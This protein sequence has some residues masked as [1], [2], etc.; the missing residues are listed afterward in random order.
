MMSVANVADTSKFLGKT[1]KLASTVKSKLS[2][3][4]SSKRVS[5]SA[6]NAE[7]DKRPS[8]LQ[9]SRKSEEI[10]E[11]D[12]EASKESQGGSKER[13]T[14]S[15]SA[16]NFPELSKLDSDSDSNLDD[17]R[18]TSSGSDSDTTT[19]RTETDELSEAGSS[20]VMTPRSGGSDGEGAMRKSLED[21]CE[22]ASCISTAGDTTDLP[23][24]SVEGG[25]HSTEEHSA[26]ELKKEAKRGGFRRSQTDNP[27]LSKGKKGGFRKS[28]TESDSASLSEH[29]KKERRTLIATTVEAVDEHGKIEIEDC[30]Q[31]S[32]S[33]L[34]LNFANSSSLD[35]KP[36]PPS[37]R[38]SQASTFSMSIPF[39]AEP[40]EVPSPINFSEEDT[41]RVAVRC[42]PF[43]SR[44]REMGCQCVV[45]MSGKTTTLCQMPHQDAPKDFTYDYS[46]WSHDENDSHFASQETVY[47]DVGKTILSNS[48]HGINGC[49]FAYGQTG[50]GKSHS[51]IG[52]PEAP[53]VVPRFVQEIFIHKASYD[54][55]RTGSTEDKEIRLWISYVEIYNEELRDLLAPGKDPVQMRI[56]DHP[57]M[58]VCVPGLTENACSSPESVEKLMDFGNKKRVVGA[59]Q[60]NAVSSR[61]HAVFRL[62]V[63]TLEGLP[64]DEEKEKA[65]EDTRKILSSQC[66]LVD[67]AG[68]ERQSKTQAKGQRLKEGRAINQ[69]LSLLGIVIKELSELGSKKSSAQIP[70]RSSKL[71]FLLKDSLAGNSRTY[72]IAA[73]SPADN[74]LVETLSTLR[75]AS[76]V[77]MIKTVARVNKDGKDAQIEDLMEEIARLKRKMLGGSFGNADDLGEIKDRQD[78]CGQMSLSYEEQLK[79][80]KQM[81]KSREEALQDMAL[82]H[83]E[84]AGAFGLD[85]KTPYL[86][87]MSDDPM[88]AGCLLFILPEGET[89]TIGADHSNKINLKGVGIPA[90]LCKIQNKDNTTILIK[91]YSD[92]GRVVVDGRVL[93]TGV[94]KTLNNGSKIFLGRAYALKLTMPLLEDDN[95]N[96]GNAPVK[97]TTHAHSSLSLEGLDDEWNALEDSVAWCSI[98]GQL[99]ETLS[100]LTEKRGRELLEEVKECCK[101]CDEATEISNDVRVEKLVFDIGITLDSLDHSH[102]VFVRIWPDKADGTGIQSLSEDQREWNCLF[103]NLEK[104][105]ER[106]HLMRDAYEEFSRIGCFDIDFLLD[107]WK[108]P[109]QSDVIRR[110][111]ALENEL[112][113]TTYQ[114]EMAKHQKTNV[115][116]K[117][118]MFWTQELM[119]PLRFVLLSW[120]SVAEASAKSKRRRMS[121]RQSMK[122]TNLKGSGKRMLRAF[123]VAPEKPLAAVPEIPVAKA[124]PSRTL[125]DAYEDVVISARMRNNLTKMRDQSDVSQVVAKIFTKTQLSSGPA[126]LVIMAKALQCEIEAL[127]QQ[128]RALQHI[129]EERN[130][131]NKSIDE[132]IDALETIAREKY[133]E[134]QKKQEEIER[135]IAKM[136]WA[137]AQLAQVRLEKE[138]EE[139]RDPAEDEHIGVA[140]CT[141]LL[142]A[143][144]VSGI[145]SSAPAL[146]K[147]R[148]IQ[149][150][151]QGWAKGASAAAEEQAPMRRGK[152]APM[153]LP[154]QIRDITND[155][156]RLTEALNS[157][158]ENGALPPKPPEITTPDEDLD[159]FDRERDPVWYDSVKGVVSEALKGASHEDRRSLKVTQI[160]GDRYM[161]DIE[162]QLVIGH[163]GEVHVQTGK[164]LFPLASFMKHWRTRVEKDNAAAHERM[165]ANETMRKKSS[166]QGSSIGLGRA[167]ALGSSTE[168]EVSNRQTTF[169]STSARSTVSALSIGDDKAGRPTSRMTSSPN[170]DFLYGAYGDLQRPTQNRV[171]PHQVENFRRDILRELGYDGSLW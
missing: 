55:K 166:P 64:P 41:I 33:S 101:L 36:P 108:E 168:K 39:S 157:L 111:S 159:F 145:R 154:G 120:K 83:S 114:K 171:M 66:N 125:L 115:F 163:G 18:G 14:F 107:P 12:C 10:A 136:D 57:K 59:T 116:S 86:L 72:M 53:G 95:G 112:Q 153:T 130:R 93:G 87:N 84:M 19:T 11:D 139:A 129:C 62:R 160:S 73:V 82:S 156:Q 71:T 28:Q 49:L 169:L 138:R 21:A 142:L 161:L 106:V 56:I 54:Q 128:R 48:L 61:S 90:K 149:S 15:D 124:P 81:E 68:S 151:A 102:I 6:N 135:Q 85:R 117:V 155:N 147:S 97:S 164:L 44:E 122:V 109:A 103:W 89:T 31:S 158:Y 162:R 110:F 16:F 91:K 17:V 78:M 113:D 141:V 92:K 52:T 140:H 24:E 119:F 65:G 131:R 170:A 8:V 30:A 127:Q 165:L 4:G 77:K 152:V 132:L 34:S 67:L 137:E 47:N 100:L 98:Q 150:R 79:Q 37:E 143:G 22:S 167:T 88:L 76:S 104:V 40:I 80:A 70:F 42:R 35:I 38:S 50:S 7:N 75:F 46:Y 3:G 148:L 134:E 58:G 2:R 105:R 121:R 69:S 123:S 99:Q 43:N 26:E 5:F 32:L 51:V 126:D 94:G 25:S 9:I 60:M 144:L 29:M 74:N 118:L 96:N 13:M 23:S 133:E 45:A 20:S 1:S 146:L 27:V 63:Q